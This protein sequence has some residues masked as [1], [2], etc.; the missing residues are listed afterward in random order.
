MHRLFVAIDLPEQV[1][2]TLAHLRSDLPGAR[3]VPAEQLHLTLRFIGDVDEL[4]LQ[5]IKGALKT[6][7]ATAFD[8]G[9]SGIGHFP[10]A[11]NPRVLWVG[12]TVSQPLLILQRQ[13]EQAVNEAGL[14]PE[15][16]KFSPH[17]TIARLKDTPARP[18]LD[19]EKRK[20]AFASPPFTITDFHLY[21][22]K[23]TG[24]GA[25]HTRVATYQL[26]P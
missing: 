24:S 22:S 15:E 1:K 6:V 21:A 25:I 16:R 13:V 8:L 4:T 10:S 11:K 23:L 9:L 20:G 14:P 19:L 7:R 17:I 26:H 18:V 2:E 12:M 3:W 5:S